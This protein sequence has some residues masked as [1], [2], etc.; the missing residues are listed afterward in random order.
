MEQPIFISE[1]FPVSFYN[2]GSV[3]FPDFCLL[4][5][6]ITD[7]IYG[8]KLVLHIYMSNLFNPEVYSSNDKLAIYTVDGLSIEHGQAH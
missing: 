7:L 4:V 2:V 8:I 6:F 5:F 1:L 3:C